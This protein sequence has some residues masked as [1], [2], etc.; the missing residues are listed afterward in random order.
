[1]IR[2]TS[3]SIGLALA[4]LAAG[5][6]PHSARPA[7]PPGQLCLL[8]G[9]VAEPGTLDPALAA[10]EQEINIINDLMVGL[11]QNDAAGRPVPGIATSWRTSPDGL[12]WTFHLR[13]AQWSDGAPVTAEDFV[14][15]MRRVVDPKTA[16][17][18]APL[19]YL[20][21]NAEAV[22]GGKAP[23][24][25][26]G[27]QAVDAHTLRIELGRPAPYLLQLAK[28]NV[29][30]PAPRQAV[31]RWG[32]AWAQP[33]HYLSTGPY[34]LK[35]WKLNDHITLVKNPRFYDADT[36]CIDQV[37][38]YPASD[39]LSAERRVRRGELDTNSRIKASRIPYLRRPDQIPAYV[40]VGV[41]LVTD[42]LAFNPRT[43]PA[44]KDRRV[45]QALTMAIDRE[46]ISGK[47]LRGVWPAAQSFVPP[48]TQNY[49]GVARPFWADWSLA[50]RQAEARRLLAA[51]GYGPEHPCAWR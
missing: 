39:F 33:G 40:H 1:V 8:A 4:L 15:G 34:L 41:D 26:L 6:A 32:A 19:L 7:C 16:S 45:R 14:F 9:N 27:V 12:V 18:Y 10:G 38:Y 36:V 13:D 23:L 35:D 2:S 25:A 44:F 21:K 48:G 43:V 37:V 30:M 17:E 49:P 50:R 11:V 5:C 51:A 46:F 42:Y 24:Q 28:H 47:V 3:A 20:L 22:N 31:A 29:M